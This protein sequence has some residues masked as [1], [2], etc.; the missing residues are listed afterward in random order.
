MKTTDILPGIS[1]KEGDSIRQIGGKYYIVN[2]ELELI[3]VNRD[4]YYEN[5]YKNRRKKL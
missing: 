5:S 4:V 2:S 3:E 1:L